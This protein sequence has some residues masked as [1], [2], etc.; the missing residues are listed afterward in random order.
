MNKNIQKYFLVAKDEIINKR[1]WVTQQ[2]LEVHNILFENWK[3]K[4]ARIDFNQSDDDVLVYFPI[5]NEEFFLFIRLSKWPD[6]EVQWVWMESWN[7]VYFSAYSEE[8]SFE[9]LKKCLKFRS[10]EWN[11]KWDIIPKSK[12]KRKYKNSFLNYD[13][14]KNTAYD[15]D[16]K[17][18]LL[19]T[20]LEKD[21]EWILKLSQIADLEIT[22][23][24]YQYISW[25]TWINLDLVTI[26]KDERFK[27]I[28]IYFYIYWMKWNKIR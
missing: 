17:L 21:K 26:K 18:K 23:V 6:I 20:E 22:I 7:E 11:N 2:Y 12:W 1:F 28:N 24:K 9:D 13:P 3:P 15:L 16:E 14:I 8:Y 19:L 10:L 5:E 27:F 4:I 25:N